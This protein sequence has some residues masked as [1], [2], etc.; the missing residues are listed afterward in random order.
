MEI[1][2]KPFALLLEWLY[3]LSG[4]YGM[5][6]II[7]CLVF[8]VI[9]FPI[10]LKGRKAMLDMSRLADKQKALQ[11]KY[12]KDRVRYSQELA[13]LY[14]AENVKPSGGCLWSFL[15]MP[16]LLALYGVVNSPFTHLMG[17]NNDQVTSLVAHITGDVGGKVARTQQLSIAQSVYEN[18]D[19][20]KTALPDVA[21]QILAAGGPINFQFMG[22]NLSDIPDI[23]FFKQPDAFAWSNVG[24]FLL[25]IVSAIFA[26]ISMK[27]ST[28]VTKKVLGMTQNEAMN[29]QMMIMQPVLSLWIGFILPGALGVYW[30]AN[31]VFA[32]LQEY[33]SI[34]LL[35]TYVVKS[36]EEAEKRAIERKEQEKEKKRIL[37]EQKKQKAEEARRIKMERSVSTEGIADGRV[38]V[39]A[40]AKGRTYD[41]NRYPVTPYHDPDD[42]CREQAEARAAAG[43]EKATVTALEN[44][45]EKEN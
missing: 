5:A 17:L 30:V 15:P 28:G 1:I 29:R 37:A 7:F 16:F 9:L 21:E 25:P 34:G 44:K 18:F 14:A 40:H 31:S 2:L 22:L 39:R 33:C 42:I 12:A 23:F 43:K 27:T 36:R 19:S 3:A 10:S 8:K 11:Q 45:E 24:L 41:A 35:K 4:S 32:I 6:I 13:D 26:V 20:V 38:G